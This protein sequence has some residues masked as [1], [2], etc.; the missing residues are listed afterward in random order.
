MLG[1]LFRKIVARLE[2]RL[3]SMVAAKLRRCAKS[4]CGG[5]GTAIG[6]DAG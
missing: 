5:R 2:R 4:S 3:S 1:E 6:S